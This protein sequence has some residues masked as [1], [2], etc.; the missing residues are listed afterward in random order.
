MSKNIEK[1]LRYIEKNCK[2][3]DY[4]ISIWTK[5]SHE[6]RFAQNTITQHIAGDNLQLSLEVAYDNKTGKARTNQLDENSLKDLIATAQNT[7]ISNQ[8]DPEYM[9]TLGK[10]VY[11][12]PVNLIEATAKLEPAEMVEIVRKSIAHAEKQDARVSGMTEK[13]IQRSIIATKKGLYADSSFSEFGHSMTMKKGEAETK[14]SFNHKDYAKFKLKNELDRLSSQMDSLVQQ[15]PFEPQRIPV[16]IR[17]EALIELISFMSW[18]MN[19]RQADEGFTPFTDQLGKNFFGKKFSL[20]STLKDKDL[21]APPFVSDGLPS[22]EITWVNKGKL[23]TMP[24]NRYWAQEK[25]AKPSQLYNIYVPGEGTT[26]AE[27]MK[28]VPKGLII[29]RFWY[30]RV[31]DMKRG[32]LTGMTRDGVL[33]FEKGKI[34]HAVNNLRWNEIPHE[35]TRR[36]LA[37]G[38]SVGVEGYAKIPPML[39]DAF[40]FVDKTS[41]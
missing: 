25:K 16:I 31:V 15:K 10:Q 1:A 32:E 33:Y 3:D 14:V 35:V 13:H 8:P 34:K 11:P 40:N 21:I 20:M 24:T 12:K 27:M 22:E 6:T 19:R 9:P 4:S 28:L 17:P 23:L 41:F 26:E 39:I 37:M 7:A 18:F 38:E 2:A 36:I 5:D 29:N 30:I